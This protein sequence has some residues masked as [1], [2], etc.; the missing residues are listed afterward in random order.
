MFPLPIVGERWDCALAPV[1][2]HQPSLARRLEIARGKKPKPVRT[3]NNL[4]NLSRRTLLAARDHGV[5]KAGQVLLWWAGRIKGENGKNFR[6]SSLKL[7]RWLVKGWEGEM[8]FHFFSK[9]E[10]E[11]RKVPFWTF[12]ALPGFTCPGAGECLHGGGEWGDRPFRC[13]SFKGWRRPEAFFRQLMSTLVVLYHPHLVRE[14]FNKLPQDAILRLYVDGDFDSVFTFSL[15]MGLLAGR[16]DVLAYGYSKS[17]DLIW[18]AVQAGV[19][20]PTNYVLNLSAGGRAKVSKDQMLSLPFT[21]GEFTTL[22]VP[23]NGRW[24]KGH[25]R[26][27]NP[28]YKQALLAEGKKHFPQQK[29]AVCPGKCGPCGG[30]KHMCGNLALRNVTIVISTH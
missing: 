1:P 6:R 10:S 27:T 2:K 22:R 23:P 15:W 26:H 17:W 20:V 30:G 5:S 4:I 19:Q 3:C 25:T 12:S 9:D 18:E 28:A 16:P 14:E 11:E 8:P 13:Y 29:V 7:G 24:K 21:R